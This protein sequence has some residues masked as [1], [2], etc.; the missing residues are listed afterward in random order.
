MQRKL[1][2]IKVDGGNQEDVIPSDPF[3]FTS[4]NNLLR[5]SAEA[6]GIRSRPLL[7]RLGA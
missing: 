1:K 2:N 6:Q 3:G 7:A 5:R 4:Y